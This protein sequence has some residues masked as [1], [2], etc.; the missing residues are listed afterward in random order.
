MPALWNIPAGFCVKIV[1]I[2][3]VAVRRSLDK[4]LRTSFL[5]NMDSNIF[6][7]SLCQPCGTFQPA[8]AYVQH[9]RMGGPNA[10]AYRTMDNE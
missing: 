8:F 10:V 7:L 1:K 5:D 4:R 3:L 9:D 6:A 2:V